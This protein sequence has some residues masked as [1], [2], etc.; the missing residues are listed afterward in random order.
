MVAVAVVMA[1]VIWLIVVEYGSQSQG[2]HR[3]VGMEINHLGPGGRL[4]VVKVSGGPLYWEDVSMGPTSTAT[5]TLPSSGE[6][7]AGDE[8]LCSTEGWVS[9]VHDSGNSSV[10]LFEGELR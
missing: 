1:T 2:E 5:C 4:T 7:T 6:I 9:I 8:V 3:A 10:V